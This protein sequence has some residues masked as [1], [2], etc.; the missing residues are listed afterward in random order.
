[1]NQVRRIFLP[2]L[3]NWNILSREII[4]PWIWETPARSSGPTCSWAVVETGA[5]CEEMTCPRSHFSS[6]THVLCFLL[7]VPSNNSFCSYVTWSRYAVSVSFCKRTQTFFQKT[8]IDWAPTCHCSRH[9]FMHEFCSSP[10]SQAAWR[11]KMSVS[12]ANREAVPLG[13]HHCNNLEASLGSW[14]SG[15]FPCICAVV[16]LVLGPTA[17]ASDQ[18][19]GIAGSSFSSSFFSLLG[20]RGYFLSYFHILSDQPWT[21]AVD[22]D[23]PSPPAAFH[24]SGPSS[25]RPRCRRS[26]FPPQPPL[27]FLSIPLDLPAFSSE[28]LFWYVPL[29]IPSTPD[30]TIRT[31]FWLLLHKLVFSSFLQYWSN[32][33][34]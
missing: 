24:A 2:V 19:S 31:P 1:M 21:R 15:D 33:C 5:Q 27:P 26:F 29:P 11:A 32:T 7:D 14:G 10:T 3:H 8:R 22:G 20:Q 30:P 4:E 23:L 17:V 13:C 34:V 28:P 25:R 18:N 6:R 16:P 12:R 9:K